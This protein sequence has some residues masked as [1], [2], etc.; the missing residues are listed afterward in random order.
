MYTGPSANGIYPVFISA[1]GVT[2][3]PFVAVVVYEYSS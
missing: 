3:G 1:V 2:T